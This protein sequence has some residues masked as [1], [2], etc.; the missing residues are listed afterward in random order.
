MA[1]Y[2][3]RFSTIVFQAN[4]I[5]SVI[6]G[7]RAE[8]ALRNLIQSL[9]LSNKKNEPGKDSILYP[10]SPSYPLAES[11]LGSRA[12]LPWSGVLSAWRQV[13]HILIYP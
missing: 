10:K 3:F 11:E 1:I 12:L 7:L 13:A 5:T 4:V 9:Y 8:E 6:Y 2:F